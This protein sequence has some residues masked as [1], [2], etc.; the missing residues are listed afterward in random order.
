MTFLEKLQS[1]IVVLDGGMGTQLQAA[2]LQAGELPEYWN[3]DHADRI[4]DIHRRYFA[5][6]ADVVYT[7]T[8]GA[9]CLKYGGDTA[10]LVQAAVRCARKAAEGFEGKFVALD[11]GPTGKLLKPLGDLDFEKA[12]EVFKTTIAAGVE[13]GVDL[14]AV[15]TM[16]DSYEMKAALL[17]AKEVCDLP[18]IA[19]CVFGTDGKMMTGANEEAAVT[20]MESLG[21]V[22]VGL[23]CSLGPQQMVPSVKKFLEFASVPVVV[24]PNAGLPRV[25]DGATH[26]DVTPADFASA[27]QTM[28]DMGVRVVGGCCGTTPAYI[29]ALAPAAK[30]AQVQPVTEKNRTVISSYT[31]AVTFGGCSPVVIGERINPTGKKRLQQALR[32]NDMAYVLGE[33]VTQGD[34]GAAVLD[35]NVGLPGIDER[36]MLCRCVEE[37]QTVTD[38]PLQIDTA[39]PTALES[40]LRL[41]NGKPLL[42]SVSGKQAVMDAVFPLAKK[43]GA[44]LIALTLDD[45]GIP[46]TAA[47][48]VAVADK[49]LA[50]AAK[51]GIA[52]KD[53]IFDTL[54]M[55]VSADGTA[56]AVTLDAME[57]LG[58]RGLRTSLGVSN[59]S[60]GLPHREHINTAFFTAA[61][62]RGLSAAIINPNSRPMMMAHKAYCALMGH[63]ANCLG[64]IAAA[65]E[66]T[67]VKTAAA[68]DKSLGYCIEKGLQQE[69]RAAARELLKAAAPLEVVNGA[70][71]PALDEVGRKFE[72]GKL[73]LPQLLMAAEAASGAFEEV[74]A[75]LGAAGASKK[76]TVVLA[77]VHGDIHDIGK[78]IVKTLLENY[79]FGVIDLG[80]DVPPQTVVEAAIRAQ[81]PVVG[82]SA[83]MTTTVG[84]M[85]ETLKLLRQQYPACRTVVGGAV[86][87]EAFAR[88]LG[89]DC[90][91]KD[92]MATVRFCEE[93]EK[94]L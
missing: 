49:I 66:E 43:Y 86:L 59:V 82:L 55:A 92:A 26:Y 31:H 12:V 20:L 4:T 14:I 84:A 63:D 83:L 77:T 1:G 56:P 57:T 47:G 27:M 45:D 28:L 38:L 93:V 8:F 42:N 40:A 75:A 2:G 33:A 13:A 19:T 46:A 69:A 41:Y 37:L 64:Y 35:V 30:A 32:D 53:L 78:N 10:H 58:K 44:A 6:G 9:N 5:A 48:R 73:F 7:N 34:N 68:V 36:E 15:E 70:I 25:V 29:A 85:E 80:K 71:V 81:A 22:A 51:Y 90:Y 21:A 65:A 39:D 89:A 79:G 3:V 88:E 91:G 87:T 61:M 72:G 62:T 52:A 54:C 60:F 17:A 74:K 67:E 16:S 50:E 23:N 11:I 24:K 18:V 76:T 94:T